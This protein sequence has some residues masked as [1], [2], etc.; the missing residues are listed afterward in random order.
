MRARTTFSA[1]DMSPQTMSVAVPICA[2]CSSRRVKCVQFCFAVVDFWSRPRIVLPFQ[3]W[4]ELESCFH[5]A[6]NQPIV[7]SSF[8][9]Q[10]LDQISTFWCR[11]TL[12][13]HV[14]TQNR[15][16]KSMKTY[17]VCGDMSNGYEQRRRMP[18]RLVCELPV[19]VFIAEGH[20]LVDQV[21]V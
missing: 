20:F 18:P 17:L 1:L 21:R 2:T 7:R 5:L 14:Q 3:S 9:T 15:L 8:T 4:N 10:N 13:L 11:R 12:L 16:A 19:L 6:T